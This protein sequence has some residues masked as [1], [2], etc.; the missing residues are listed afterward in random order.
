VGSGQFVKSDNFTFSGTYA[1]GSA[2]SVIVKVQEVAHWGNGDAPA[3]ARTIVARK[4]SSCSSGGG[5]TQPCSGQSMVTQAGSIAVGGGKGTVSFT[6]GQGCD[7]Q[8]SLVSYKAPGPTWDASRASEQKYYASV[9]QT[10]HAGSYT[11]TVDVPSCYYQV[12][13]VYGTPIT[14]GA[15]M[16]GNRLI[17]SNNG[18][19]TACTSST[20]PPPSGGSGGS[21]GGTAP[22]AP[23]TPAAPP[24]PAPSIGLVKL[25]RVGTTGSFVAGPV[26]AAIGQTVYYQLVVKNNGSTTIGVSVKDD[27]CDAGTLSPAGPQA[28]LTGGTLTLTCSH[29]IVAADGAQY[30]NT[31]LATAQ[32]ASPQQT[33]VTATA[34]AKVGAGGVAGVTKTIR[35]AATPKKVVKVKKVAKPA[36]AV[37]RAADFTG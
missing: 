5:G 13:F 9:T 19:T 23:S 32:N 26:T 15:P 36:R 1:A 34:V 3:D 29:R 20:T 31:A 4:A 24:V 7:V 17:R 6:V 10:L 2:T 11:W 25:E 16:Y 30:V 8:L 18:G 22:V 21:G 14:S 28:I 35:K 12:D 33:S 37:I 27:G